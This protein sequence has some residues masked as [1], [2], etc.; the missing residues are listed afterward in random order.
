[1]ADMEMDPFELRRPPHTES[2]AVQIAEDD[3]Q[4]SSEGL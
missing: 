1:M 3:A 4:R 2:E